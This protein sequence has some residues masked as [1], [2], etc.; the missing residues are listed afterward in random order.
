ME[1][2]ALLFPAPQTT[3]SATDIEGEVAYLPRFYRFN[4]RYLE[5]RE[6]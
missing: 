3:Y 2:N 4:K 1:M 6:K 5:M